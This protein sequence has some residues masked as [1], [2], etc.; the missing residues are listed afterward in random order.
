[1]FSKYQ[2]TFT[3]T[4]LK[5]LLQKLCSKGSLGASLCLWPLNP[6]SPGVSVVRFT[7]AILEYLLVLFFV[8]FFLLTLGFECRASHLLGM[9]STS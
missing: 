9:F 1:M 5:T 6:H 7:F 4:D 8:F 3:W 2:R